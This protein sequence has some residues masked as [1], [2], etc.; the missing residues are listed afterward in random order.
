METNKTEFIAEVERLFVA[1]TLV[2]NTTIA[3]VVRTTDPDLA[4]LVD[5][6]NTDVENVRKYILDRFEIP[7][8]IATGN[9]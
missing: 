9:V 6:I 2:R 3:E 1:V 7:A 5:T 4:K 8:R